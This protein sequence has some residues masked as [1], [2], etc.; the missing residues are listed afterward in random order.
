M[1]KTTLVDLGLA[2]ARVTAHKSGFVRLTIA[3]P[4]VDMDGQHVP[5]QSVDVDIAPNKLQDF[6]NALADASH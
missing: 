4:A 5:P 3:V 1:N 6:Y 2:M